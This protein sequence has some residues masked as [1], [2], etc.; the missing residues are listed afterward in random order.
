MTKI[1]PCAGACPVNT[2]VPGYVNA[3]T[4]GDYVRAV[5]LI[6]DTNPFASVCGWVCPHPC[7]D[8]CRRAAVD[9]AVSIRCLKRFAI[10]NAGEPVDSA[11]AA[12]VDRKVAVLG[13]GPAGLACAWFLARRGF[14]VT[15]WERQE[16]PGG[17][18]AAA[19]PVYRLPREVLERDVDL[20]REAGV[21]IVCGVEIGPDKP[22]DELRRDYDAVV[23]ATGLPTGRLCSV[24]GVEHPKV[25]TA[26]CFLEQAAR[27]AEM[28]LGSRVVV[29]GGGDVA[30]D[31]ARTARRYGAAE[32]TVLC[33]EP[34]GK[35][36]A[37]VWEIEEAQEEGI[38][39]HP[40]YGPWEIGDQGNEL[41]ISFKKVLSLFNEQG[42]FDPRL[43]PEVALT[44]SC[45]DII[46]AIGQGGDFSFLDD[47]GIAMGP[48]GPVSEGESM[49]LSEPGVF[50]C[51]EAARGPG[52]AINA[53]AG[54]LAAGERVMAYLQ[55]RPAQIRPEPEQI[56][57]LPEREIPLITS[58]SRQGMPMRSVAERLAEGRAPVEL[59]YP[60]AVAALESGRCMGCGL[61]AQ[62]NRNKCMAC[63]TCARV[64][65]F[66]VPKVGKVAVI[67]PEECQACGICAVNCPAGAISLVK[68]PVTW[69]GDGATAVLACEKSRFQV[70]QWLAGKSG[71][72]LALLPS[73]GA[74]DVLT[75]LKALEQGAQKI[76]VFTCGEDRCVNNC[77]DTL[78]VRM[79]AIRYTL[80]Q[81]GW[82]GANL[83]LVNGSGDGALPE[84]LADPA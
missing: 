7:E 65:P 25:V 41:A 77:R 5:R 17:Q 3:I 16:S 48:R 82:D 69:E 67:E 43:A 24:P 75:V 29:I 38:T 13:A 35:I 6:R 39:I 26:L 12:P 54:G 55:G 27:G 9:N 2:D 70:R 8:R 53:V 59:G 52:A 28:C 46:V 45:D 1:A 78:A 30:M 21:E 36:P 66:G 11:A 34:E 20:I 73:A 81:V 79:A 10:E 62:V 51:G 32:V 37:H 80:E 64:C 50:I 33:L 74:L 72:S 57:P 4:R 76:L 18:L 71:F 60:E 47:S 61:G 49:M 83:V 22:F 40:G 58:V 56:G 84:S 23:I 19:L 31:A 15:V 42:R 44:F 14:R 63:L 68:P